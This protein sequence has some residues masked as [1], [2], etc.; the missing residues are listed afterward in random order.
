MV[1]IEI[2][3]NIRKVATL[4]GLPLLGAAAQH[5][6][7]RYKNR[8]AQLRWTATY[9]P[10]AFATDDHGWGKV[11]VLYDGEH[12][13]NLHVV[14]IEVQNAS[15]RDLEKL[16]FDIAA[17]EGSH[18]LRSAGQLRGSL[19]TLPHSSQFSE[20]LNR[21]AAGTADPVQAAMAY[22]HLG[23]TIPVL[24]RG[25]V[26]SFRL[27]VARGDHSTPSI[28]VGCDHPGVRIRHLPLAEE[29]LGVR[30]GQAQAVGL[31]SSVGLTVG[32]VAIGLQPW[33]IGLV[34]WTAG[35]AAIL[36]GALIVRVLRLVTS[37]LD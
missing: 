17:D 32:A 6:W 37:L 28:E 23:F 15:S 5:L 27:L 31:L 29:T 21:I 3:D 24:N 12:A 22:R 1:D 7:S 8:L 10:M 33:A 9:T 14:N 18:V 30:D 13:T 16:Q 19:Q 26:V 34:A 11:E 36:I 2:L 20:A 4:V 25:Q 35:A